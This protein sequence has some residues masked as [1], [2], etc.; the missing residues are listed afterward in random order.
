[1]FRHNESLYF[2]RLP[3]IH[4]AA[5]QLARFLVVEFLLPGFPKAVVLDPSQSSESELLY[6][7]VRSMRVSGSFRE[8]LHMFN[9]FLRFWMVPDTPRNICYRFFNSRGFMN[10]HKQQR[11]E[12]L[13]FRT[14]YWSLKSFTITGNP[15]K[16]PPPPREVVAIA[17]QG[18]SS[19]LCFPPL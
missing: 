9:G 8:A 15:S 2:V 13:N 19:P 12:H 7:A 14:Y 5:S 11:H 6:V 4:S 10:L 18:L 1:M 3:H 17:R 16:P